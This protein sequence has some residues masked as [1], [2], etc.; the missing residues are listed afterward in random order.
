MR[1]HS[2]SKEAVKTN[3][4]NISGCFNCDIPEHL[5]KYFTKP[6][7]SSKAAPRRL[8]YHIKKDHKLHAVHHVLDAFC[9]QLYGTGSNDNDGF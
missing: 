9:R 1:E 5:A 8:E 6:M 3:P 4:F 7:N 2:T